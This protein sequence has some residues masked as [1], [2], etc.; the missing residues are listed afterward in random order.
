[1]I[2]VIDKY[3][4][5]AD[6]R[7]YTV[8]EQKTDKEGNISYKPISYHIGLSH[9]VQRVMRII[10]AERLSEHDMTIYEAIREVKSL[11]DEF[12]KMLDALNEQERLQR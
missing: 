5:K 10:Q 9:A 4:I 11:H 12:E 2:H 6:D 1:M 3:Y 8:C 7:D